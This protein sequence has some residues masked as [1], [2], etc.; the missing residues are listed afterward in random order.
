MFSRLVSIALATTIA[1]AAVL[2]S[3]HLHATR[4]TYAVDQILAI[5]PTSNTCD[6]APFPSECA[7]AAQAAP[8][9]ITAFENY[10]IMNAAQM[11]AVISLMAYETDDFKYNTNHYPGRPGQGTRNMQMANYNLMYALSIPELSVGLSLITTATTATGLA[12]DVLN[13]I[14]GLVLPDEYSFASGA[15][16]L[17]T[18]CASAMT[19]L[20]ANA[21][22]GFTEYMTCVGAS[23]TSDRLA[24]FTRAKAAFGLA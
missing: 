12:D 4:T 17:K 23:A 13:A 8:H 1:S 24:Y 18:Q 21:D 16:F 20:E 5:A 7:T 15:W 22:T 11:A 19:A 14:L 9:L 6:G 3:A 10:G 2:P